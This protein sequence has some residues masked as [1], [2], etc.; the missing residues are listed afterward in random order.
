MKAAE[1]AVD[2]WI[3]GE[4]S[5]QWLEI[6]SHALVATAAANNLAARSNFLETATD[7]GDID[8]DGVLRPDFGP[9]WLSS[10]GE[11]DFGTVR[12]GETFGVETIRLTNNGASPQTF[13]PESLTFQNSVPAS[14][15]KQKTYRNDNDP[16]IYSEP[17]GVVTIVGGASLDIPI[18]AEEAGSLSNAAALVVNIMVSTLPGVTCSN[19]VAVRAF[20]RESADDYR[21]R[22]RRAVAILSPCGAADAYRYLAATNIDGTPLLRADDLTPVAITRTQVTKDSVQGEVSGW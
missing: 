6:D 17:G 16:S 22:C 19:P 21:A 18:L 3:A 14:D 12:I 10:K 15:G 13:G 2:D 8:T 9:A 7:P 11:N 1:L 5:H 20:D 4:P